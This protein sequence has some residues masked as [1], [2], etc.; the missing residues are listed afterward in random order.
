M[1]DELRPQFVCPGV[2]LYWLCSPTMSQDRTRE[3]VVERWMLTIVADGGKDRFDD[4]HIDQIDNQWKDRKT[5]VSAGLEAYQIAMA[6]RS[7]HCLPLVVA[8]GFSL[9]PGGTSN[10]VSLETLQ[11]F[12]CRLNWS[13]PSL[14]LFPHGKTPYDQTQRVAFESVSGNKVAIRDLEPAIFGEATP[15]QRA[16]YM[17]FIQA[18]STEASASVF[19]EG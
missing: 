4:L 10:E 15:T 12:E 7:R 17:E 19:I 3:E 16:Y 14:Y 5:W 8:L 18:D 9:K 2:G 6:L 1:N 11:D 13:P